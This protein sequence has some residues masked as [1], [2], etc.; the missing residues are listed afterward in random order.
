MASEFNAEFTENGAHT[1]N[2]IESSG[3]NAGFSSGVKV[4]PVYPSD[5]LP[6]MD[7]LPESGVSKLYS[8]S[9]HRHPS[10]STKMNYISPITNIELEEMLV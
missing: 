7:G 3:F 6:L 2:F 4:Y 1:A 5:E 9:D 10:D 8:R